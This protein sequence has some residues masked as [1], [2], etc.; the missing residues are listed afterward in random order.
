M[1]VLRPCSPINSRL[2]HS[3]DKQTI[4]SLALPYSHFDGKQKKKKV[5]NMGAPPALLGSLIQRYRFQLICALH[6]RNT[7]FLTTF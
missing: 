6:P 7:A 3:H 4:S 5:C 2:P 1:H